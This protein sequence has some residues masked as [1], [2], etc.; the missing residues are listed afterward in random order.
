MVWY[1]HL[2]GILAVFTYVGYTLAGL[3]YTILRSGTLATRDRGSYAIT[4]KPLTSSEEQAQLTL[5]EK[6]QGPSDSR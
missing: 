4:I 3:A 2:L 1:E 5:V 6:H